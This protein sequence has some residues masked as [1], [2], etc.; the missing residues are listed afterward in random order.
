LTE[1]NA[2]LKYYFFNAEGHAEECKGFGARLLVKFDVSG[3]NILL[4]LVHL[5]FKIYNPKYHDG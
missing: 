2:D 4:S 1:S 3:S 5:K